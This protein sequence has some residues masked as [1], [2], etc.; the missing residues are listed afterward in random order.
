M[1]ET[2]FRFRI[3]RFFFSARPNGMIF[4]YQQ[5]DIHLLEFYMREKSE[6]IILLIY[7][8]YFFFSLVELDEQIV[9]EKENVN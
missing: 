5:L 3:A 7:K 8:I 9:P 6:L 1:H 4:V 2:L